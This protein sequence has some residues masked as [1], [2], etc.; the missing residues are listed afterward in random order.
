MFSSKSILSTVVLAAS[1]F[2]AIVPS[3]NTAKALMKLPAGQTALTAQT[4]APSFALL[5]VGVQNYTCSDAG[6]YASAGAVA[7]LFDISCLGGKPAFDSIA[8]TAYTIWKN[9][10]DGPLSSKLQSGITTSC[11]VVTT[12]SHFFTKT[13]AGSI[14]P[15]WDMRANGPNGVKGKAGAYVIGAK[16]ANLASPEG[17]KNVDWLQLKNVEGSL[18]TAIYRTD[19]HGGPAPASCTPGSAPISVKYTSKYFLYGSTVA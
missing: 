2:A 10:P 5:G 1:A 16:V 8:K 3:C 13:A 11:G 6:T 14:A 17:A 19:T 7:A 15:V 4:G 18:A 9:I 12:G